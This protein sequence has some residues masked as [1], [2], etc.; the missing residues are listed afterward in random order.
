[1]LIFTDNFSELP[2]TQ[3]LDVQGRMQ[4]K[5]EGFIEMRRRKRRYR[6]AEGVERNGNWGGGSPAQ[7]T[8]G[9]GAL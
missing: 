2:C 9:L 1:M 3:D 6:D 7:Q 5:M 4:K 8:M